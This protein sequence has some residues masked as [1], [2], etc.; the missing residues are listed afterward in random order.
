MQR[1]GGNRQ[2]QGSRIRFHPLPARGPGFGIKPA[3]VAGAPLSTTPH[4]KVA[5]SRSVTPAK[6]GVQNALKG[7]DPGFRRNDKRGVS[8]TYFCGSVPKVEHGSEYI[9]KSEYQTAKFYLADL[10]G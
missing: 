6:A 4:N 9:K 7:L 3:A 2:H 8:D 5:N 1:S 10:H